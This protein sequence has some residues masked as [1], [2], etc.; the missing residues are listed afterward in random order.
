MHRRRWAALA[1][2]AIGLAVLPG[3]SSAAPLTPTTQYQPEGF[4]R[5]CAE[6]Q[7]TIANISPS[8]PLLAENGNPN[9]YSSGGT[10]FR[11]FDDFVSSKSSVSVLGK[12]ILTTTYYTY[13]DAG[14]TKRQQIRCKLRTGESLDKGAWPAGAD[15]N[16]G[17]FAVDTAFGFG[18]AATGLSSSPT[19]AECSAIN[20]QTIQNVWDGLSPAQQ[21]SSVYNLT[22][23]EIVTVPDIQTNIGPN[24]TSDFPAL[25]LNQADPSILEVPSKALLVPTSAATDL[26]G[27]NSPRFVGAHY[28]TLVG[29]EYLRDVITGASAVVG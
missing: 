3:L 21:A 24:W 23:G 2:L 16:P 27:F 15:N 28:C 4:F 26:T 14:K 8:S 18:P 9:G 25:Q 20:A 13:L 22:T 1:A 5:F 6:A 12:T 29:P 17:R 10:I 19:D 7:K 11:T